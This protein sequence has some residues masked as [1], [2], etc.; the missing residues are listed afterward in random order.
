MK[1]EI[2][3]KRKLLQAYFTLEASLLLPFVLGIILMIVYLWF[4]QYDRCLLEQDMGALALR[5]SASVLEEKETRMRWLEGQEKKREK[6]KYVGW[7]EGNVEMK[8][9]KNILKVEGSGRVRFPF[10][11]MNFWRE[12][13]VWEAEAAYENRITSPVLFVRTCRKLTGGK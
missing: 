10:S 12:A 5:G 3:T 2:K 6:E 9:E 7:E 11:G 8:L 4:F 13:T 1:R